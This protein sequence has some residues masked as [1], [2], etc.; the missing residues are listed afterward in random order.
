MNKLERK[1]RVIARGE[2]SNHAH[3]IVGLRHKI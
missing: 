2:G 1:N 3:V